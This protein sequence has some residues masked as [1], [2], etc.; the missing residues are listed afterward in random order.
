[1]ME[2][3][4]SLQEWWLAVRSIADLVN[5]DGVAPSEDALFKER[6]T[7][8]GFSLEGIGQALEWIERASLSGNLMDALSMLTIDPDA[9]RVQHPTERVHI[10]PQ[11]W[12]AIEL[13]K[14]RGLL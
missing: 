2:N 6:L 8:Q 12:S 14:S 3:T 7:E 4:G 10:H 1:M 13:G 5:R 9:V 11:I